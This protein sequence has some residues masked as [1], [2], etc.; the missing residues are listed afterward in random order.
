MVKKLPGIDPEADL[1][2]EHFAII[3]APSARR[4]RF[5][6]NIVQVVESEE[7]ARTAAGARPGYRP[8][9]VIG[10]ARSSEGFKLYYL[11]RWLD[12]DA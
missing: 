7:A 4:D 5:P 8:A 9:Q 1:V 11:L 3:Y 12:E 2:D 10:P 6:E